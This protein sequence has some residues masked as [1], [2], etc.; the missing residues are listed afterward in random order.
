M[1]RLLTSTAALAALAL[2]V[3]AQASVTINEI[4][5]DMTGTDTDEYFELTGLPG[6][7]LADLTYIVIGDGTGGSGVIERVQSLAGYSIPADGYFLGAGDTTFNAV[8]NALDV[9]LLF[10]PATDFFEN[11]DNVT[12]VLVSGFTGVLAQ[13][14]D[15]NDDGVLD[16]TPWASVADMIALVEMPNP[17]SGAGNE[18]YYGTNTIGPD[19]TF[20]PGHIYR[21]A[22][23]TGPWNIGLFSP[24]GTNDTPGV[25]N[26][27]EPSALALL[28]LGGLFA[29]RRR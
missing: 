11:S 5:I 24:I 29:L 12:H 19:G 6:E 15:T 17:P 9:D 7:S 18:W 27:P 25:A 1:K 10:T 2:A 8:P 21:Y 16:L 22:N 14:L 3:S 4:R 26:V 23:G 28:A 13:D 20:V